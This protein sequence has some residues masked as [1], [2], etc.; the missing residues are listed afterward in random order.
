MQRP[1]PTVRLRELGSRLRSLRQSG[2]LTLDDVARRMMVSSAK[3]SRLET[4]GRGVSLRDVRDLCDIY[5]LSPEERAHL[6]D[7]A[8]QAKQRAWWQDFDLPFS[9]FVGLEAAATRITEYRSSVIPGLLQT[10]A[11]AR[12]MLHGTDP[13]LDHKILERRVEARMIRQGLLTLPDPP[14][15]QAVLDEAVLH[16]VVGN[17]EVMAEQMD[18]LANRAE[19]PNVSIRIAPFTA[20]AHPGIGSTFTLLEFDP[21]AGGEVVYVEG[22][23]GNILFERPADLDRYRRFIGRMD[24]MALDTRAS[25]NFIGA[26]ARP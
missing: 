1:N 26:A 20:G 5:G 11:Y 9:D 15:F 3:L 2:G 17:P 10:E 25:R 4:G 22:L 19:L 12:A 16:H 6:M 18:A 7:L 14:E 24:E 8:L 13:D 23:V 21:G